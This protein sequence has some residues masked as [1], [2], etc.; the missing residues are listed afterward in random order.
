M[1]KTTLVTL[2][3]IAAMTFSAAA[4]SFDDAMRQAIQGA[5][6]QAKVALAQSSIPKTSAI[7]ALPI[8]GDREEYAEG[9]L[10]IAVTDAGKTFVARNAEDGVFNE[11]LKEMAWDE[12]KSD[13]LDPATIDK[14]GALKSTQILL[15]GTLRVIESASTHVFAEIELHAFSIKTKEHVW[16]GVFAKRYY[17][18]GDKMAKGLSEIPVQIRSVMQEKLTSLAVKSLQA[19]DKLAAVKTVAYVPFS[20]DVDF[21]STYIFRDAVTKTDLAM[22]NLGLNTVGEARVLLRD[23]PLEAD[24]LATGALRDISIEPVVEKS[25]PNSTVWRVNV[26][27][28][29]A[30]E[31]AATG[32]ILWSDTVLA[33]SEFTE[34][35]GLWG[36]VCA[37]LPWIAEHQGLAVAGGIVAIIVLAVLFRMIAAATRV[38]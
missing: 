7:S 1:K 34:K 20:G 17:I 3:A 8:S 30:I 23:K 2:A 27:F 13:M 38:R 29:A 21:Y 12:R 35:L 9:L 26:E 14:F 24:A 22:R 36:W 10:K 15:S 5:V 4:A 16:G 19:Q 31:N 32:D 6:D 37:N 18:P 33:S 28:Q 25:T 11:I